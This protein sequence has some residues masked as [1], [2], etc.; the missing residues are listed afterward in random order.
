M[1][2]V[3]RTRKLNQVKLKNG[4]NPAK[5]FEKIKSISDLINKLYRRSE[6]CSSPRERIGRIWNHLGEYHKRQGSWIDNGRPRISN[7]NSMAHSVW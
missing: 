1:A 2:E 3:E 5:L 4:D 6:N 7:E